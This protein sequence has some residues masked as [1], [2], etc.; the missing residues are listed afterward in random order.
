MCSSIGARSV[1]DRRAVNY[2]LRRFFY[3]VRNGYTQKRYEEELTFVN[4]IRYNSKENGK[5]G[6]RPRRKE[7]QTKP[8]E[9]QPVITSKVRTSKV[10]TQ[11]VPRTNPDQTRQ[12][13]LKTLP[14]ATFMQKLGI[15]LSLFQ[16]FRKVRERTSH[17][18]TEAG[19]DLTFKEL[20]QFQSQGENPV[21]VLEQA[22]RTGSWKL[23]PVKNG[24]GK[25][26]HESFA[27][28]NVRES[29]EVLA[30]VRRNIDKMDD[31]VEFDV[32]KRKGVE[33]NDRHLLGSAG[34]SKP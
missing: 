18:L 7:T 1:A 19:V 15:S 8:R 20:L 9:T 21:E 2:V 30:K 3:K 4:S 6:G 29:Q 24:N 14:S 28:R 34:R 12:E 23:Y 27:E 26:S 31:E 13:D 11:P 10:E 5:K 33:L 17:P 16:D 22:V 32:P 25:G